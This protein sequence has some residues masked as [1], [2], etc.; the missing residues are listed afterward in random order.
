MSEDATLRH[1]VAVQALRLF[2]PIIRESL[3]ASRE[4]REAY[5][6]TTDAHIVL[7]GGQISF[8]RSKFLAMLALAV[9][10]CISGQ[11]AFDGPKCSGL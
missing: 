8:M 11:V 3:L 5:N 6:L 10:P 2:P 7:S 4:F 9:G 1:M